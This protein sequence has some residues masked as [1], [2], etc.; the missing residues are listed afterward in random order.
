[1]ELSKPTNSSLDY[2]PCSLSNGEVVC[3]QV[4][5]EEVQKALMRN[6]LSNRLASIKLILQPG[7][8][9]ET[10][11]PQDVFGEKQILR[12]GIEFPLEVVENS[13]L[14]LQVDADA[15]RSTK[16]YTEIFRIGGVDCT[17]LDLSFLSGFDKLTE[18]TFSN[19]YNIQHCLPSLPPLPKLTS[20]SFKYCT[21]MN[22]LINYPNLT[23]GL[24]DVTF[25]ADV[26]NIHETYND[27]TVD[28]IMN[29]LLLS[30]AT[31]LKNILIRGMNQVTRVPKKIS[32]FTA[33]SAISMYHNNISIIEYGAFSFSVPVSI[34]NLEGNGINNIEPYAFKG[35]DSKIDVLRVNKIFF[36]K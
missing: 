1:M 26:V 11:I 30:S 4:S 28:R 8:F 35:K 17:Q 6:T 3:D 12:I 19:I 22:E 29:W 20:L 25:F 2:T 24:K 31:T 13:S 14:I 15:F 34:L 32:S 16:G 18:F 21:G 36:F 33:L 10:I 9:T 27:E 7:I 5:F 23:N